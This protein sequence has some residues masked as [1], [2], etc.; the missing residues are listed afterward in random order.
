MGLIGNSN[1]EKILNFLLNQGFNMFGA[2]GVM[3]LE[4]KAGTL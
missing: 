4:F 3:A 1:E 2:C